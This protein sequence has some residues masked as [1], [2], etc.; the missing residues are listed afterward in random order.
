[1][2]VEDDESREVLERSRDGVC[3]RSTSLREIIAPVVERSV[4][5]AGISTRELTMKDFAMEGDEGKRT[6][7][8][9]K[10]SSVNPFCRSSVRTWATILRR[11]GS[12]QVPSRASRLAS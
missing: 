1:L 5:I 11:S 10:F 9:G 7:C 8:S 3:G 12:L 2:R 6:A 4:T